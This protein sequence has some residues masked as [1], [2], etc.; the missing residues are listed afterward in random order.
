MAEAAEVDVLGVEDF[1]QGALGLGE[2][3]A[4]FGEGGGREV[5]ELRGVATAADHQV[6]G[7]LGIDAMIYD[8]MI[9][10]LDNQVF[11][12]LKSHAAVIPAGPV[13]RQ[14]L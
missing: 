1:A 2:E 6:A 7:E 11:G 12:N 4:E 10:R 3:R 13:R 9:G 14:A 5:G 8:P